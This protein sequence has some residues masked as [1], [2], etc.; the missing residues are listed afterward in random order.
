MDT[1]EG[2]TWVTQVVPIVEGDQG[3]G[4]DAP[5]EP[6][7]AEAMGITPYDPAALERR[8]AH[9]RRRNKAARQS[10]RRNRK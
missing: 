6:G 4:W 3:E 2:R 7:E 9:N 5:L 1:Y 10:R 8:K